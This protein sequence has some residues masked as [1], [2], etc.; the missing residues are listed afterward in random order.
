MSAVAVPTPDLKSQKYDRQLRLWAATGQTALE[1]ATVCLLGATSTGCEVLKNLILPGVGNITVVDDQLVQEDDIRSNFFLESSSLNQ[2]KAKCVVELLK[3]LNEDVKANWTVKAPSDMI[4]QEPEFFTPFHTIIASN[5]HEDD[6]IRLASFCEQTK[7]VLI[8]I[9]S[10]GLCGYFRIQAPEH[11]IIETHPENVTDLRLNQPFVQLVEY[12]KKFDL[13]KLD[14]TDH[15]HV[16]FVIVILKYIEDWKAKHDGKLPKTYAERNELKENIKAG[17]RTVD[18]ENFDEAI[19]NV[20]RLSSSCEIPSDVRRIFEDPA[21]QNL[22]ADSEPFWIIA[23]AIADFV[24]NEGEGQL[25]LPGKLPDMKS[26]TNNYIGLQNAYRQKALAD[27]V[28]VQS[29]VHQWLEDL[30]LSRDSIPADTIEGFCKNAAHIKIIRYRSLLDEYVAKPKT[31]KIETT[32]QQDENLAYYIAYRAA[33]RF[34]SA[35]QRWPG[36]RGGDNEEDVQLL[37]QQVIAT[38]HNLGLP[39]STITTLMQRSDTIDK[40]IINFVRFNNQETP[41]LAALMG[42][43]VSQE[44]IKLITHQY[45]PLNN[46]CVFNGISS[47]SSVFEL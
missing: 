27:L 26:D 28:I 25:P 10:K 47:T 16:P 15:A 41:N 18:E 43:L 36:D 24:A 9:R 22:T 6:I 5:I 8:V 44:V 40:A 34:Y 45:V 14:Q 12:A 23:R 35:Y 4:L 13:A 46:T 30:E 31:Q 39:E 3:E 32:L 7:K 33:D 21:C 17:K 11:A 37:R 19:A 1:S 2:P 38:L 29:R 20:W 42:G